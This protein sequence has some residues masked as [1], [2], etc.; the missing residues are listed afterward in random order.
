MSRFSCSSSGVVR[1]LLLLLM[2]LLLLRIAGRGSRGVT[3]VPAIDGCDGGLRYD[4]FADGTFFVE[5]VNMEP[6]VETRPTEE[7]STTSHHGFIRFLEANVA[8]KILSYA[9]V[10]AAA[11][12]GGQ[13]IASLLSTA[14]RSDHRRHA[15]RRRPSCSCNSR[16]LIHLLLLLLLL[17]QYLS[18]FYLQK[19][20]I[21]CSS[22][23]S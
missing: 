7:M 10:V 19:R 9:V 15:E 17:A 23:C 16:L 5:R 4:A 20:W 18:C 21:G 8:L 11:A 3:V 13:C 12:A 14:C 2:L 6:T 22:S 1:G